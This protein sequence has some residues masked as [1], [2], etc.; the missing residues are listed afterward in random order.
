M[1][2]VNVEMETF[3]RLFASLFYRAD[4]IRLIEG[5]LYADAPSWQV[6]VGELASILSPSGP[7]VSPL[8]AY[9][10]LT[11]SK[12]DSATWNTIK[13]PADGLLIQNWFVNADGHVYVATDA[14]VVSVGGTTTIQRYDVTSDTWSTAAKTSASA[15]LISVTA[16]ATLNKAVLWFLSDANGEMVLYKET[17]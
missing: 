14:T 5:I 17:R 3:L 2:P 6:F 11:V 7:A 9:S 13:Q 4:R 1:G 15:T 10:S 8:S 12:D 16:S